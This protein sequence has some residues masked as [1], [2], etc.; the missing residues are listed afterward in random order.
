MRVHTPAVLVDLVQPE[1]R[2]WM[3]V[4]QTSTLRG[5]ESRFRALA[6]GLGL[7]QQVKPAQ[8]DLSQEFL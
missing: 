5:Q 8:S 3:F 6:S 4:W 1:R 7:V 2:G